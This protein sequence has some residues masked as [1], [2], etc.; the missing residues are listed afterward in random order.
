LLVDDL[1]V[2]RSPSVRRVLEVE[3]DSVLVLVDIVHVVLAGALHGISIV[4]ESAFR[5]VTIKATRLMSL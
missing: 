4:C 2:L 3:L 1:N 5:P